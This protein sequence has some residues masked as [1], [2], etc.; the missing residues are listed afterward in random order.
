MAFPTVSQTDLTDRQI[1]KIQE[2]APDLIDVNIG[3]PARAIVEA[4]TSI[5]I[6][7]QWLVQLLWQADRLSTASGVD[8]DSFV[9]DFDLTRLPAIPAVGQET[10][11][12][13]SYSVYDG[14]ASVP[15]GTRVQS[16][17]NTNAALVIADTANPA[18]DATSNAYIMGVGVAAVTVPVQNTSAGVAGNVG[19]GI[20]VDLGSAVSGVDR[21]TNLVALT[22]GLDA[23]SD[24]ALKAR[25]RLY[26]AGLA[27]ADAAAINSAIANVQQGL[28]WIVQDCVNEVGVFRPGYF[29]VRVDD[30]TGA[31]SS[32]LIARV[33]AAVDAVRALGIQFSVLPPS[34]ENITVSMTI[35]TAA[36]T[37][38]LAIIPVVNGAISNYIAGLGFGQT[39]SIF[40]LAA[41]AYGVDQSITAV[42]GILISGSP[43]D[44]IAGSGTIFRTTSISIS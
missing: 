20:L 19:A 1:A 4:N 13:L 12:R 39:L 24:D 31:P 25:F 36:G 9:A 14:T 23:E 21:C 30:G 6:W 15:V 5:G 38:K 28:R 3:S 11:S 22:G 8:V 26:I 16:Q 44:K 35:S 32:A 7:M 29:V 2:T 41:I 33:Y 34:V 10:F 27:K 40:K 18:Y 37:S 17:D 43:A 42:S